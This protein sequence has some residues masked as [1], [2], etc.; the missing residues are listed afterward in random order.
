MSNV[1]LEIT[2]KERIFNIDIKDVSIIMDEVNSVLDDAEAIELNV[3]NVLEYVPYDKTKDL[4]D[5]LTTKLRKQGKLVVCGNDVTLWVFKVNNC[6]R[7]IVD[8][9]DVLFENSKRSMLSLSIIKDWVESR[10]NLTM[11]SG[12]I[13][14]NS[15]RVEIR[16]V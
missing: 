5:W 13:N 2:T 7:S 1:V 9:N 3:G 11:L 12:T 16:R 4:F 8:F 6:S 14:D 15:Y 10:P